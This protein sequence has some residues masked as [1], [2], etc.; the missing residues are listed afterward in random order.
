MG[1]LIAYCTWRP[2]SKLPWCRPESSSQ[3][4]CR[5]REQGTGEEDSQAPGSLPSRALKEAGVGAACP[6]FCNGFQ[7]SRGPEESF[8]QGLWQRRGWFSAQ[9]EPCLASCA[10]L[11]NDSTS[12]VPRQ[13]HGAMGKAL[14]RSMCVTCQ[15]HVCVSLAQCGPHVSGVTL[16]PSGNNDLATLA[17]WCGVAL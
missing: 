11:E 14:L 13:S 12:L 17:G 4:L 10:T 15:C 9:E 1:D 6:S 7:S 8:T 3:G 2:S 5:G 16:G